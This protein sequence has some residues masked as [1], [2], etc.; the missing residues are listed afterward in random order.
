LATAKLQNKVQAIKA[1]QKLC[2]EEEAQLFDE[3]Q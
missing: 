1:L 3:A 2:A